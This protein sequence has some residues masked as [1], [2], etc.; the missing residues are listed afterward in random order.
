[1][2][3]LYPLP[4]ARAAGFREEAVELAASSWFELIGWRSVPGDY[5]APGGAR[6]DYPQAVLEPELRSALA[7]LNPD[8]APV[9]VRTLLAERGPQAARPLRLCAGPPAGR[10][11]PR[12]PTSGV[13]GWSVGVMRLS[14]GAARGRAQDRASRAERCL[15]QTNDRPLQAA[16]EYGRSP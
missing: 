10:R 3:D 11:G 7:T 4:E 15:R 8:A 1:M 14:E 12:D 6:A 5:L 16:S 9:I 13:A 2:T